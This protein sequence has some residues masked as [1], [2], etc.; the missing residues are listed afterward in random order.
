MNTRERFLAVMNFQPVDRSLLW[1]MGYWTAL[2]EEYKSRDYPLTIGGG[3][4]IGFYGYMRYLMGEERLLLNFYD[5]PDLVKDMM[6]FLADF[7]I[8][9]WDQA[10]SEVEVDCAH[11]WEDMAFRTRPLISPA[12]F[13]E[14]MLPCYR[15]V[16]GFL[17]NHGVDIILVDSDGNLDELIPLFLEAGLTGVWPIEIQAGNDLLEIRKRYP[18]LRIQGGI[19][20]LRVAK[21]PKEIDE[22]LDSK[23]PLLLESG[24]YIPH[25]DHLAH[26]QIS[27]QDFRHYR[28]RLRDIVETA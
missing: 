10:L 7:W 4:P 19:D 5:D 20:K 27:W 2:V 21:G 26:P 22:E 24:G 1:E 15:R 14:F 18:R 13:R 11:F 23:L 6:G 3:Y 16:T 17:R 12:M 8:E 25:L 28:R 9:L